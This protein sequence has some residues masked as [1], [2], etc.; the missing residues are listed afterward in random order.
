MAHDSMGERKL[1]PVLPIILI[2]KFSTKSEQSKSNSTTQSMYHD[3]MGFF[4]VMVMIKYIYSYI[5]Q[6]TYHIIKIKDKND[7]II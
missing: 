2:K 7:I 3:Q 5:Y 4:S 6:L 1:K